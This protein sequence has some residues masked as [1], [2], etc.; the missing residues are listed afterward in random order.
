MLCNVGSVR[1]SLFLSISLFLFQRSWE[2]ITRTGQELV[3]HHHFTTHTHGGTSATSWQLGSV[4][5]SKN[6]DATASWKVKIKVSVHCIALTL[7]KGQ[8]KTQEE[9]RNLAS[10]HRRFCAVH[11]LIQKSSENSFSISH[12]AKS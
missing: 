1:R 3:M 11:K 5:C 2:S 7:R 12:I 6:T 10:V 9:G 4:Y 8:G